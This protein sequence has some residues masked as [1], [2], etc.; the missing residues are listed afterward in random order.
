MST[1]TPHF[2]SEV[3]HITS[4][5]RIYQSDYVDEG[6]PFFRSREI[7]ERFNGREIST[8]LFISEQKY[9][10]IDLK[11]GTP[12][13]GDILLT[14]VGTLGIP[15]LVRSGDRFYFKD[16][17]LTWFRCGKELAPQY[18]YYWLLSPQGKAQQNRARIGSSQSAYTISLLKKMEIDLPPAPTQRRI[19]DI[20]SAYDNLVE[21]NNR[22]M[23]LLEE[24]IHLLYREWFVYLRFPGHERTEVVDGVPEGWKQSDLGSLVDLIQDRIHPDQVHPSTPYVGLEH[25]PRRCIAL[26]SWGVAADVTSTKFNFNER[27]LLFGKIRPYF[28]KIVFAPTSGICSS[29]TIVMRP[30]SPEYFSLALAVTSSV[31]FVDH[32][33][34]TSKIGAKMPRANWDVMKVY[35]I[36]VPPA[37]LHKEFDAVVQFSVTQIQSLLDMNTKL[38]EA[39]DLLL[40]RLMNG[41]IPV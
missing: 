34:K 29:D 16:G 8:E 28:H 5:K 17:N 21:N 3:C 19:A 40:P 10:D 32:V 11:F 7:I 39:R 9:Q 25:L 35:P 38:R 6:I 22:R 33:W 41:R 27:D 2:L 36:L 24:S 18:L 4:S 20:L 13:A 12:Q 1:S 15:Y 30:K 23:A 31:T 37:S 26:S 14:S